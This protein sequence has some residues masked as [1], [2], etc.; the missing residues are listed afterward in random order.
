MLPRKF[1]DLSIPLCRT[2][3]GKQSI[4]LRGAK[5]WNDLP[6]H[7]KTDEN[8]RLFKS[9]WKTSDHWFL[10]LPYSV[11]NGSLCFFSLFLQTPTDC[12]KLHYFNNK[13]FSSLITCMY[14][15]LSLLMSFKF[16]F[17]LFF[18]HVCSA[19]IFHFDWPIHLYIVKL[20]L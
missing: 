16:S 18:S 4:L 5:I 11:F 7:L 8:I 1:H 2:S 19:Y 3:H 15:C 12:C 13:L 14:I 9:K 17:L 6:Q 10:Y 20:K